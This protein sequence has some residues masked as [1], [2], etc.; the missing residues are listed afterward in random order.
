[1][2]LRTLTIKCFHG[3]DSLE[4]VDL[5]EAF[6]EVWQG[7]SK[8]VTIAHSVLSLHESDSKLLSSL[9]ENIV[10]VGQQYVFAKFEW[11]HRRNSDGCEDPLMEY[12][13]YAHASEFKYISSLFISD[14][15]AFC[16]FLEQLL[17]SRISM[18]EEKITSAAPSKDTWEE[19]VNLETQL[20][21]I[22]HIMS[23]LLHSTRDSLSER[24]ATLSDLNFCSLISRGFKFM[25]F[26]DRRRD[27]H[28]T[29]HSRHNWV[30]LEET[31]GI[32]QRIELAELSLCSSL[33]QVCSIQLRET[34]SAHKITSEFVQN[35][36]ASLDFKD[37]DLMDFCVQKIFSNLFHWKH[38]ETIVRAS[39]ESIKSFALGLKFQISNED[40]HLHE[41]GNV[42]LL[43]CPTV[44]EMFRENR[45]QSLSFLRMKKFF[46]YRTVFY[47]IV[48]ALFFTQSD[49]N[50]ELGVDSFLSELRKCAC[51]IL[52]DFSGDLENQQF[53]VQE[54]HQDLVLGFLR[55][56]RGIVLGCTRKNAFSFL[57]EWFHP[58]V[59]NVLMDIA[60]KDGHVPEI[61][62]N[63]LKICLELV[64]NR[65]YVVSRSGQS[66][67]PLIIFKFASVI[68]SRCLHRL[69]YTLSCEDSEE[70]PEIFRNLRLC[71]DVISKSLCAGF[72]DLSV[73][74]YYKDSC[75]DVF[76]DALD[77]ALNIPFRV[78][79]VKFLSL[80]EC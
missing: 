36:A 62:R 47:H 60:M 43:N 58:E 28:D 55:D 44:I 63:V 32:N 61:M 54:K 48:A 20:S 3:F 17:V 9:K 14:V 18:F 5:L 50:I 39:L 46:K 59:S 79:T 64:T 33:Y 15:S 66:T 72:A 31:E 51:Q 26:L 70:Y 11:S 6:I 30:V 74:L 2:L 77:S 56:L 21:W 4:Y 68:V 69:R 49:V 13:F 67:M 8:D 57:F 19:Y 42:G 76:D 41:A 80:N 37:D 34:V 75:T 10:L 78:L 12:P 24:C 16:K 35:L 23:A 25:F 29:L 45:L 73:L 53:A 7:F 22:F 40:I 52:N 1:V 71:L 38:S 65:H 27:T